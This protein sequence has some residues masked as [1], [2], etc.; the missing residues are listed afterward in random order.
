[1]PWNSD[2]DGPNGGGPWGQRPG[3]GNQPPDLEDLIRRGQDRFK[4]A[5]PGGSL[6]AR[7]LGLGFLILVALWLASGVYRVEPYEQGV[8]LQFGKFVKTTQ[9]GLNYHLPWPF[10]AA[11]T[12]AV[13]RVNQIDV[14]F[15]T[16]T[17]TN[18]QAGPARDVPE[19]SLMLTGDENIVDV[20]FAVQWRINDAGAF[21]FNIQNPEGTIKAVAEST[22]REVIGQSSLQ[23]IL[24]GSR[25][26]IERNVQQLM[27]QTLDEY[28]AGVEITEVKSQKVDPPGAVIDA[29][30]D[31]QAARADLER[32]RNEADAYANKIVP[33][34][35]GEAAQI[36]QQAEAYK[37]QTIAEATGEAQRFISIYNEYK[38]APDV[39]RERIF[40]ETMEKVF[41]DMDKM[42][43]SSEIG[44]SG[45]VPYLPLDQLNKARGQGQ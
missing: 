19:E 31:V 38:L 26:D 24:T 2:D 18:R 43:I 17:S 35:R 20:D 36:S 37:E 39:T 44:G 30:R 34:A 16:T 11:L 21:L 25:G 41:G 14:G 28:G 29:F 8:V 7:G 6:G 4:Q 5:L 32:L 15:R 33:E 10:E 23:P 1:M 13:T 42:I 40:L 3:G 22:M 9:P 12:P 27:Q 45:V